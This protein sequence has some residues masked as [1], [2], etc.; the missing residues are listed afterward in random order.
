MNSD[1]KQSD[2]NNYMD[3]KLLSIKEVEQ[4]LG[5]C[6]AMVQKLLNYRELPSIKI[7][8]RRFV[9]SIDLTGYVC[10]LRERNQSG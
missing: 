9:S 2:Q 6:H 5:L 8:R 4:Y 3:Y 1:N 7:G 10:K